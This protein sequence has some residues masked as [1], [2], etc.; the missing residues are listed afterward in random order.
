MEEPQRS[1]GAADHHGAANGS[2][3]SARSTVLRSAEHLVHIAEGLRQIEGAIVARD[4]AQGNESKA[5]QPS[6]RQRLQ[7]LDLMMQEL[8]GLSEILAAVAQRLPDQPDPELEPLLDLPRLE[9]L[10]R[11]L[12]AAAPQDAAPAIVLF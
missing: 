5:D 10:S 8:T 2:V 4:Q 1:G 11:V 3:L 6:L 9:S 7:G 12:R